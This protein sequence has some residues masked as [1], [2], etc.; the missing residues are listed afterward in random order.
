[1]KLDL[2]IFFFNVD[3]LKNLYWTCHNIVPVSGC[4][5]CGILAP[6]P[7]TESAP[8]VLE[9]KALTTG[10]SGKS[11][12]AGFFPGLRGLIRSLNS[13]AY[14]IPHFFPIT[15]GIWKPFTF[16]WNLAWWTLQSHQCNASGRWMF[17][18]PDLVTAGSPA[19]L[20]SAFKCAANASEETLLVSGISLVTNQ[21]LSVVFP[22]NKRAFPFFQHFPQSLAIIT[23]SHHHSSHPKSSAFS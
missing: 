11:Q 21:C 16:A 14:K 8:S 3:H 22:P 4:E 15:C 20:P 19:S 5:A 17:S 1:M 13:T 12:D 9:G 23:S 7:G 18:S 6:W 10:L 2:G